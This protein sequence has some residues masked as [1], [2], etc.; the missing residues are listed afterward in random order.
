MAVDSA[1][2]R[3]YRD[4]YADIH[5]RARGE[6]DLN[7]HLAARGDLGRDAELN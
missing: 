2:S 1:V 6:P 4:A 5:A 7:D 3:R